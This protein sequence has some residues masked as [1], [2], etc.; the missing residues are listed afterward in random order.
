[1][2][3]RDTQGQVIVGMIISH[4]VEEDNIK[5]F[6]PLIFL[7]EVLPDNVEHGYPEL[8]NNLTIIDF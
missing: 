6:F 7:I 2:I 5:S 4:F 8:K 3:K 1:M